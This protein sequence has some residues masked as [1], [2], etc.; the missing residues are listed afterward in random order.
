MKGETNPRI[1]ALIQKLYR[2]MSGFIFKVIRR[3]SIILSILTDTTCTGNP[4]QPYE[5]IV[6]CCKASA[7]AAK[8]G[9]TKSI[10]I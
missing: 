6:L 9:I 2:F 10:G 5:Q 3:A 4:A 7:T 1:A 8:H